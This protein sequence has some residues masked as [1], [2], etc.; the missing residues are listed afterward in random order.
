MSKLVDLTKLYDRPLISHGN[1]FQKILNGLFVYFAITSSLFANTILVPTDYLF[2]QD[3]ISAAQNGDTILVAP[4]IYQEN[5]IYNGKEI[6]IGSLYLITGDTTYTDLTIIDGGGQSVNQSTVSF[7]SGETSAA[8]LSGFTIRNGWAAGTHAGGI[9]VSNASPVVDGCQIVDNFGDA[10]FFEGIGIACRNGSPVFRDCLIEN[11]LAAANGNFSHNGGGIFISGGA[12]YFIDCKIRNN[13][14]ISHPFDRNY[15]GALYANNTEAIFFNCLFE[16]N[17]ADHGGAVYLNGGNA[18]QTITFHECTFRN[19]TV[20]WNGAA[21]HMHHLYEQ[22]LWVE[23]CLFYGN[24]DLQGGWTIWGDFTNFTGP[25]VVINQMTMA[26]NLTGGLFVTEAAQLAVSNS[27]IYFNRG[28]EIGPNMLINDFTYSNISG[29]GAGLNNID[30]DPIFCNPTLNDYQLAAN[31]PCLTAGSGGDHMG[32]LA[33]GCAAQFPQIRRVPQDYNSI[34][35]AL[36]SAY[37]GDTVLVEPGIY[38]ENIDFSGKEVILASKFLTTGD[39]SLI[40]Q[41]IIDAGG[42]AES[43][44]GVWF[45]TQEGRNTRLIGMTI[46]NH[47]SSGNQ[48]NG[49][50]R[51]ED[52]CW[53]SIEDCRIVNN[54]GAPEFFWGIGVYIDSS[55]PIFKNCLFKNNSAPANANHDHFGGAVF[56]G[57]SF[58]QPQFVNC[59]FIDNQLAAQLYNE[60]IHGGAVYCTNSVLLDSCKFENNTAGNGGAFA[61]NNGLIQV[62]NSVIRNN[63]AVFNGGAMVTF[64][65]GQMNLEYSV[66]DLNS[67]GVHGGA[68][69]QGADVQSQFNW[70]T[71]TN[72]S[73]RQG[74]AFFR[75][76]GQ[77]KPFVSGSIVYF[78][79]PQEL[80]PDTSFVDWYIANNVRRISGPSVFDVDPLFLDWDNQN[81]AIAPNSP[82]ATAGPNGIPIGAL[83]VSGPDI[84]PGIRQVPQDYSTINEAIRHSYQGDTVLLAQGT[85]SENVDFWGRRV[86]LASNYVL[87]NDTTDIAATIIDGGGPTNNQSVL[88]FWRNEDS[89][90]AVTGLTITNGHADGAHSGGV[91]IYHDG[92]PVISDCRIVNNHGSGGYFEGIGVRSV[93]SS[94]F[95]QRCLIKNN[96]APANFNNRHNGGGIYVFGGK[97]QFLNCEILDNH[98]SQSVYFNDFGG[99][100][101]FTASEAVI[102]YCRFEGNFAEF[103][104]GILIDSSP[105]I[106]FRNNLVVNNQ[107]RAN[108]GGMFI[109]ASNSAIINNT[110]SGNHTGGAGGAVYADVADPTLLNNILWGNSASGG[111]DELALN[112]ANPTLQY[113]DIAGGWAGTGNIDSNPLFTDSMD[114]YLTNVSPCIDAGHPDPTYN[115]PQDPNN[116]GSALFPAMGGLRNDMGAYGGSGADNWII[117][118]IDDPIKEFTDNLPQEFSLLQNYPNPFNPHTTLKFGLAKASEVYLEVYNILGQPVARLLASTYLQAGWYEIVWDGRN[119]SGHRVAS[120]IYL[121]RLQAGDFVETKKMILMK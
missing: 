47:Y 92:R 3:A 43:R 81:Y 90:S 117:T 96:N 87:T 23:N 101:Y 45:R 66:V 114:F 63:R 41:T 30:E 85:H 112:F 29:L 40:S 97:P 100:A 94:P 14:I 73:A 72:N 4:G 74:G 44:P 55:E 9:T 42:Q 32:A 121:Y 83:G 54:S 105:L 51:I 106:E 110:F 68:Y 62:W 84:I 107:S 31:S 28:N 25:T 60:R 53:P 88:T 75:G 120:G 36:L 6:V 77:S 67:A 89:L 48:A 71:I 70:C 91:N 80:G 8:V 7:L 116:P 27:I 82:C 20:K 16:G 49:A 46:T 15:G 64:N 2:I 11:N 12:P 95:F 99:G 24:N 5:I 119:S 17:S 115:D 38:Q 86:L 34:Q 69:Y 102:R 52:T 39:T 79:W 65:G 113:N 37:A 26:D 76:V 61:A 59:E 35:Q 104:G 50:I 22:Q 108:A 103:G 56:V 93:S 58:F 57:G 98:L 18:S 33:Q 1:I 118:G 78:N 109:F 21:I 19:N 111:S 13:N 10:G